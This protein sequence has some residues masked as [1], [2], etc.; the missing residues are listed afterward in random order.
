M[1]KVLRIFD[2]VDPAS[3]N[4]ML[5]LA[6]QGAVFG[7]QAL[8]PLQYIKKYCKVLENIVLIIWVEEPPPGQ[9][10]LNY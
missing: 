7:H 6:G 3:L 5:L 4:F 8:L 2:V 1:T 10:L 9:N